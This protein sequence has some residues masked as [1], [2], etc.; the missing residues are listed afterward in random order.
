M[1]MTWRA[2][3]EVVKKRWRMAGAVRRRNDMVVMVV[4]CWNV[5]RWF[6]CVLVVVKSGR[7]EFRL[8]QDAV[9]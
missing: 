6:G 4:V 3:V 1:D 8:Y 9:L 7:L 2:R 5:V